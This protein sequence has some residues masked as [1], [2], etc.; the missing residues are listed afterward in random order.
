MTD[1]RFQ[2]LTRRHDEAVARLDEQERKERRNRWTIIATLISALT[3]GGGGATAYLN[4]DDDDIKTVVATHIAT[5]DQWKSGANQDIDELLEQM[6]KLRDAVIRLQVTV[7]N[8]S[9]KHRGGERLRHELGEVGRLLDG[10]ETK[11]KPARAAKPAPASSEQVQ[12]YKT[13]LFEE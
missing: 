6:Q 7:E 11:G 13:E 2:E 5:Y 1:E 8:L 3:A 10:L 9:E 12:Q 4:N